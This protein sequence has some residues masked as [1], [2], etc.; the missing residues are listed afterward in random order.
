ME[1]SILFDPAFAQL[2]FDI[3]NIAKSREIRVN[4]GPYV[5]NDSILVDLGDRENL[6]PT[7]HEATRV[8]I[9]QVNSSRERKNY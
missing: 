7:F 2:T 9:S 5:V 1:L 3:F 6:G 4:I 8:G